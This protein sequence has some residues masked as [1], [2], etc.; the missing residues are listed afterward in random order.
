MWRSL[1]SVLLVLALVPQLLQR[2]LLL[3][4]TLP[5]SA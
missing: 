3:P 2:R 5:S 4:V 1:S